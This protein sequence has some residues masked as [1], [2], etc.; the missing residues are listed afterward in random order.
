MGFGVGVSPHLWH[1]PVG[2]AACCLGGVLG[3]RA[4][5]GPHRTC[6]PGWGQG[7]R[8]PEGGGVREGRPCSGKVRPWAQS[9]LETTVLP[10][11]H[12]EA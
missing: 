2:F 8:G 11:R 9:L 6:V 5:S 3:T 10:G 12:R 7:A 1:V 4:L